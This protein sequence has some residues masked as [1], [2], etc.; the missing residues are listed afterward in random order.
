MIGEFLVVAFDL[1]LELFTFGA[2]DAWSERRKKQ[3]E[4]EK[5]TSYWDRGSEA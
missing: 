3:P 1:L 4:A 5:T 2:F